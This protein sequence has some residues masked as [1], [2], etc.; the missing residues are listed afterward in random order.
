[1]TYL[2]DRTANGWS[3]RLTY[4]LIVLSGS[5]CLQQPTAL[6]GVIDTRPPT[7]FLSYFDFTG[8]D[9]AGGTFTAD[10]TTLSS[11][12]LEI[13]GPGIGTFQAIVLGTDG[14][15]APKLP[16]LWQSGNVNLPSV[17]TEY[18]FFPGATLTAGDLYFI[19][20]DFGSMT[21]ATG[22]DS[23]QL[24][25]VNPSAQIPIGTEWEILNGNGPP[26]SQ[27]ASYDISSRIEMTIIPEPST[28]ALT[29]LGVVGIASSRRK[30]K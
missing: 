1:M 14:G 22:S 3:R 6:G 4:T 16:I 7:E 27:S 12:T 24:G 9:A 17:S 30:R 18:T 28:L 20:A 2:V 10:A 5:F 25:F 23:S 29:I 15:G 13:N 19:G 26:N 21:S 11:F 8:P